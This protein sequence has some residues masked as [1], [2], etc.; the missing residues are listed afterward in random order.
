MTYKTCTKCGEEFE[1]T[2]EFFSAR[3]DSKDGLRSQCK[4]CKREYYKVYSSQ[5]RVINKEKNREY[6]DQYYKDNK[7][8]LDEYFKCY[9]QTEKG[10]EV[11]RKAGK[12]YRQSETGKRKLKAYYQTDVY[13]RKN[14]VSK[15]MSCGIWYSL[16][17][18]KDGLR[19][20][21]L[22]NYNLPELKLHLEKLFQQG[23]SWKNYGEWHID[24]IKPKVLFNITSYECDD[25]KECWALE[26]LQPLWASENC[27]KGAKYEY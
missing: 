24:H 7:E 22:V 25:F 21:T 6:R 13:K 14:K 9:Y 15:N 16:N 18:N 11:R 10:K 17:G 27:S 4:S 20:E 26:N 5:W 19:W 2:T 3:K 23:M 12:K 8:K 1:A